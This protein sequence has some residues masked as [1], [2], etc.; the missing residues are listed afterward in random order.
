MSKPISCQVHSS[1]MHL[2]RGPISCINAIPTFYCIGHFLHDSYKLGLYLS[3]ISSSSPKMTSQMEELWGVIKEKEK[4]IFTLRWSMKWEDLEDDMN[5]ANVSGS[6][7]SRLSECG[8][9]LSRMRFALRDTCLKNR[10]QILTFITLRHKPLLRW[11]MKSPPSLSK[12][13]LSSNNFLSNR[14][15][16]SPF[17]YTI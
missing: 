12:T 17:T 16:S 4:N 3:P 9:E 7:W 11:M 5:F 6:V 8:S 13:S 2:S 14:R 15:L 10:H 1:S